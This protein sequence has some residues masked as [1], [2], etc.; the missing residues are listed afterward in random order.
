M[1]RIYSS[2]GNKLLFKTLPADQV[3][4]FVWDKDLQAYPNS[5]RKEPH[6][7]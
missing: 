5:G 3:F 1:W 6:D 2:S 4:V 7:R